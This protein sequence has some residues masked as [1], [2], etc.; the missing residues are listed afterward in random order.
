MDAPS[1]PAWAGSS[2][3]TSRCRRGWGTGWTGRHRRS[4]KWACASGR[5][6]GWRW[7]SGSR[8][9]P[10]SQQRLGTQGGGGRGGE[11]RGGGRGGGSQTSGE[12]ERGGGE[13]TGRTVGKGRDQEEEESE[14]RHGDGVGGWWKAEPESSARK[15]WGQGESDRQG[16]V[17]AS[18]SCLSIL[19]GEARGSGPSLVAAC[20]PSSSPELPIPPEPS[21]G[22]SAHGTQGLST[23]EGLRLG[24]SMA[25]PSYPRWGDRKGPTA[26]QPGACNAPQPPSALPLPRTTQGGAP[27]S[28]AGVR[29]GETRVPGAPR[30]VRTPRSGFIPPGPAAR[31]AWSGW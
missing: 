1:G 19:R 16:I 24:Y 21:T 20:L 28:R 14:R 6:W 12:G 15:T 5:G 8:T 13:G 17:Q 23:H 4:R 30:P 22:R 29:G 25:R 11:G 3:R 27:R 7:R 9:R 31:R 26:P 10:C 18:R 2:R